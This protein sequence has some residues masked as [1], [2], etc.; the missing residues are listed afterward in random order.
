MLFLKRIQYFNE[1]EK[2]STTGELITWGQWYYE[3]DEDGFIIS[4]D[5]YYEQLR[6]KKEQTFDYSR[7]SNAQNEKEYREELR[8][9]EQSM[10]LNSLFQR[11]IAGKD[12][13]EVN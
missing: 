9:A 12:E 11:K 7:L 6:K 8:K 5:N 1:C 13:E 2:D 4:L 10:A 3:D